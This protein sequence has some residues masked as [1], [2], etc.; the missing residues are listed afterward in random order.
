MD[1]IFKLFELYT[2]Y[3]YHKSAI[4]HTGQNML[5]KTINAMNKAQRAIPIPHSWDSRDIDGSMLKLLLVFKDLRDFER[6]VFSNEI[7][8]QQ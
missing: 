4:D 6:R 5:Q 3:Q 8:G 2:K 7:I 1:S